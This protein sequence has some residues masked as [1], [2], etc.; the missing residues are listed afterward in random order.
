MES[1]FWISIVA[2]GALS[3]AVAHEGHDHTHH[4][5]HSA[6]SDEKLPITIY[7]ESLCP[8][9]IRF[10]K[11]QLDPT[12]RALGKY[13]NIEFVPYGKARQWYS[14]NT[15]H[16]ECQH[17]TRECYG[18]IVQACAINVFHDETNIFKYLTCLMTTVNI[19]Q[20]TNATYPVDEC[21]SGLDVDNIKKCVSG[22]EGLKFLSEMGNRTSE[23]HPPLTEVPA[24]SVNM[25][26]SY[27]EQQEAV[28]NFKSVVCSHLKAANTNPAD[29]KSSSFT[30][31]SSILVVTVAS[32]FLAT[33]A[34]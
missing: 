31:V 33:T 23:L 1:F 9:S 16:F 12:Y 6:S 32:L 15:Y 29:C 5:M 30:A 24:I 21:G 11:D 22:A 19:T 18:N 7:Y 4:Q 8:D 26:F 10:F 14:N 27:E 3:V 28:N 25:T 20:V 17:G 2:F 13:L 34:S